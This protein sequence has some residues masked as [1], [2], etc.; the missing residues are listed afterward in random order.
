[1]TKIID[2]FKK[3]PVN[4]LPFPLDW[5][6]RNP[7]EVEKILSQMSVEDQ[8]RCVTQCPA[9]QKQ[10]LL[11]LSEQAEEVVHA[12]PPEE[13]YQMVKAIC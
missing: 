12:L 7:R 8:A 2:H 11:T 1:M 10:N 3:T 13:I 4:R 5:I 9:E 6:S